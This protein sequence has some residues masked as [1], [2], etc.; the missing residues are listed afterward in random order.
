MNRARRNRACGVGVCHRHRAAPRTAVSASG[1]K[2]VA[3]CGRISYYA[4]ARMKGIV[5]LL[6]AMSVSVVVAIAFGFIVGHL[7]PLTAAASLLCGVG[8]AIYS[9]AVLHFPADPNQK[10]RAVDWFVIL[11][12]GLFALRAFCWLICVDGEDFSIL[13]ENNFSDM[14]LHLTLI[15]YL[16]RGPTFWPENPIYSGLKLHYPI[17]TDLFNALLK[18]IGLNDIITLVGIGLVASL[19]T[20]VALYRW[21]KGFAIAGFLFNGGIGIFSHRSF[22][23]LPRRLPGRAGM[24]EH[25]SGHV[26]DPTRFALCH[27]RRLGPAMQLAGP[28]VRQG[29]IGLATATRSAAVFDF[30][31]IQRARLYLVLSLAGSLAGDRL[32]RHPS[33]RGQ[34]FRMLVHSSNGLFRADHGLVLP[35]RVD[36]AYY[37]FSSGLA[38]GR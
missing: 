10:P 31:A 7:T 17:G 30:A 15:N 23:F 16:A 12:F 18:L 38:S 8:G 21:G 2:T 1:Y 24:E 36:G 34:T 9:L 35:K 3:D 33:S 29:N 13:S 32:T 25:R 11:C 26:H 22:H 4:L 14:P 37:P 19:I 6:V 27:S 28:L 5:A 20:C